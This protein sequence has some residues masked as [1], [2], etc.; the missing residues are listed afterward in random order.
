MPI[1][2]LSVW[3]LASLLSSSRPQCQME[4]A[5]WSSSVL[6]R[7]WLRK[8][9]SLDLVLEFLSKAVQRARKLSVG[10]DLISRVVRCSV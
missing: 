7:P 5:L 3:K 8:A 4:S 1:S 10:R 2:S 6:P 9:E